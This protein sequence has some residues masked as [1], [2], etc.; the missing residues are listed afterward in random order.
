MQ[1]E[2][3]VF[4]TTC[5]QA[6]KQVHVRISVCGKRK[7]VHF[8]SVCPPPSSVSLPHTHAHRNN[9]KVCKTTGSI[10][11]IIIHNA[12]SFK[13]TNFFFKWSIL[14]IF[15]KLQF[16]CNK[17]KTSEFKILRF[18]STSPFM[19]N[20]LQQS[21]LAYTVS[22]TGLRSSHNKDNTIK[23]TFCIHATQTTLKKNVKKKLLQ[24]LST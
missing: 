1:V 23:R 12:V 20:Y 2:D 21:D 17:L 4:Q 9:A 3:M 16:L 24:A 18:Y 5:H 15:L 19:Y 11:Q 22:F 10:C 7:R 6:A 14:D 8:L 13:Y